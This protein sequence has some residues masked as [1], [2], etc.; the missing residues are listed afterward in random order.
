MGKLLEPLIIVPC[1]KAKIWGKH[2]N[3]GP[4]AV[5]EA[6]IGTPFKVNRTYAENLTNRWLV[7]SAKYGFVEP[8]FMLGGPYEV[9]FKDNSTDPISLDALRQQA[10]EKKLSDAQTVIGLGGKEYR[11]VLRSIFPT[12]D[13]PF[14]GLSLFEMI[15]KTKRCAIERRMRP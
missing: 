9:T 10:I 7:L 14:E 2:P 13:F 4:V 11:A 6:Y 3:A 15:A 8:D 5:R 12:I 1:G